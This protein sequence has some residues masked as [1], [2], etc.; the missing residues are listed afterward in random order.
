MWKSYEYD[1]SNQAS[2][3]REVN[4]IKDTRT[5]LNCKNTWEEAISVNK[6]LTN[7]LSSTV[8]DVDIL[9]RTLKDKQNEITELSNRVEELETANTE[10]TQKLQIQHQI[11]QKSQK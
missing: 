1:R 9:A 6:D 3:R 5:C 10:L 7:L 2:I 8:R 11:S 4:E